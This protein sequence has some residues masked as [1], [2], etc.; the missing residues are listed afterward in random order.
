[1]FA[2]FKQRIIDVSTSS[3]GKLICKLL[4]KGIY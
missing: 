2:L 4:E 3:L 1:M